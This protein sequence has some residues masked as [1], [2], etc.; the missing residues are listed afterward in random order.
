M[1]PI[2]ALLAL[3]LALPAAEGTATGARPPSEAPLPAAI[4]L[5]QA[6]ALSARAAGVDLAA[7]EVE[8]AA[9]RRRMESSGWLPNV[10]ASASWTRRASAGGAPADNVQPP[11]LAPTETVDGRLRA[12]QSVLDWASIIRW[13]AADAGIEAAEAERYAA[14]E[15]AAEAA[16]GRY[17]ALARARAQV[18]SRRADLALAEEL[19]SLA[20]AQVKVG[21]AEAINS[22]RARTQVSAVRGDLLVAENQ[23]ERASIDLSR[24]LDAP[25]EAVWMLASPFDERLAASEAP[26]DPRQAADAAAGR[27]ELRTTAALLVSAEF[28]LEAVQAE[29][30]PTFQVFGDYGGTGPRHDRTTETWSFGVQASLSLF[31]GLRREA[32][33]A[34]EEA[35]LQQ[36][37]RRRA[38]LAA[39]VAAEARSAAVDLLSGE[40]QRVVARERLHLAELEVEQARDRFRAGVASNID[41]INAQL[42]LSKAHDADI[43]TRAALAQARVRLARAVGL[44]V[45][46]R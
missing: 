6:V 23:S 22:T 17:V 16:A 21:V 25:A 40:Q 27:P 42:S 13:R 2:P 1:R 36:A 5:A 3:A 14:L 26:R 39:Q 20:D 43:D 11:P 32:R 15:R 12:T 46:L 30:L 18:V 34:Q 28:A 44:A 38:D 41:V 10:A 33:L 19:A 4:T 8:V 31:D 24:P 37:R 45:T 35:Q 29:Y 7:L 9:A